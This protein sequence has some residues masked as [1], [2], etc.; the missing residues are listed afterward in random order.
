[1]R[2]VGEPS[3][4][5]RIR[6][7]ASRRARWRPW[8]RCATRAAR[9]RRRRRSARRGGRSPPRARSDRRCGGSRGR[10]VERRRDSGSRGTPSRRRRLRGR[11]G[12]PESPLLRRLG[13]SAVR[14][15]CTSGRWQGASRNRSRLHRRAERTRLGRRT[16]IS[17]Y[18]AGPNCG[19]GRL[20]G[21]MAVWPS[22]SRIASAVASH[23]AP[24]RRADSRRSRSRPRWSLG[25]RS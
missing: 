13:A 16:A 14:W 15:T 2:A 20:I 12:S 8:Y 4:R 3:R 1:M 24:S 18:A 21:L 6:P 9:S 19:N 10:V 7:R 11:R 22:R 25:A 23:R 17:C 5:R